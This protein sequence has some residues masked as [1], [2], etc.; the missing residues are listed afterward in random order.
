MINRFI[1][2]LIFISK[3]NYL[4]NVYGLGRSLLAFGTL[5][6]FLF[7]SKYSLIHA[8]L[9]EKAKLVN[10]DYNLNLFLHF[11]Y[12]DLYIP[13]II[14]IIILLLVL[15]GIY[16]RF[17][18]ILHWWVS[19][20]FINAATIVEGG[21]Q[22]TAN[23]TFFLIPITILDGRKNHWMTQNKSGNMY[24]N[25]FVYLWFMLISIQMS[26]LYLQAGIEKPYKVEE[27]LNGTSIYYWFKNNLFG[28]NNIMQ[29]IILPLLNVKI[30]LFII[31]WSVIILELTL[32]G[33]IF[34]ESKRK[35]I[36]FKIAI[37]FHSM[38]ALCFGLVSFFFAMAGALV[39]YLLPKDKNINFKKKLYGKSS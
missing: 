11:S 7:N 2:D 27:W 26:V 9:F 29:K 30:I 28:L 4:T 3:T 36:L 1:N 10:N 15:S 19:Y 38:I 13:W 34:M 33:G 14:S 21:D 39:L 18:G 24:A 31:N 37:V 22:I 6:T 35:K 32:A 8:P 23:L 17:T 16:P 5:L 12:N 25:L 20:S